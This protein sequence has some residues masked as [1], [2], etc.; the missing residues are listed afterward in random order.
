MT[1]VQR[2]FIAEVSSGVRQKNIFEAM[3]NGWAQSTD[4]YTKAL[5]S[6]NFAQER[7]QIYLEST[8]AK[9]AQLKAT[10]DTMFQN[11]MSSG[12]LNTVI[13]GVT[14]VAEAFSKVSQSVGLL[15]TLL[16]TAVV[17]LN[18]FGKFNFGESLLKSVQNYRLQ[19]S[20]LR[21]E[22]SALS[23]QN[24][25]MQV[26]TS[27]L[28]MMF[29]ALTGKTI[30]QTAA[31]VAL[32]LATTLLNAALTMGI[33]LAITGIVTAIG[34]W[35]QSSQRAKELQE[36]LKQSIDSSTQS[37]NQL[38]E[39]IATTNEKSVF[40]QNIKQINDTIKKYDDL[41]GKIK[42]VRDLKKTVYIQDYGEVE[43][44]SSYNPN[45]LT[46]S[47]KQQAAALR[48]N[49]SEFK[50][51]DDLLAEIKKRQSEYN[52][53]LLQSKDRTIDATKATID[54][55]LS[56]SE[57]I[58][59]YKKIYNELEIYNDII[60]KNTNGHK[61]SGK[62][63]ADLVEKYPQLIDAVKV[64]A[65]VLEFDTD[66]IN[67]MRQ[68]I[69]DNRNA[70]VQAQID[71]TNITI[72]STKKRIDAYMAEINS[73]QV[74]ANAYDNNPDINN[75]M[76]EHFQQVGATQ[77]VVGNLQDQLNTLEDQKANLEKLKSLISNPSFGVPKKDAGGTSTPSTSAE[78]DI[79]SAQIRSFNYASDQDK[80]ANESLKKHIEIAKQAKDYNDELKY[81]NLLL[82]GNKKQIDDIYSANKKI[83]EEKARVK[84]QYSFDTS[85]WFDSNG[86]STVAYEEAYQ[87][88]S[89][90]TQKEMK[91][92]FDALDKL[93]HAYQT[94]ANTI[95]SVI[96]S[97]SS[98]RQSLATLS[99]DL[100]KQ[101][102]EKEKEI[103]QIE[104][105]HQK[106]ILEKQ[107]KNDE[108]EL[109]SFK[110]THQTI[111]NG[112]QAQIDALQE[113]TNLETEEEERQ[114]RL[115]DIQTAQL[116]LTKAQQLLTNTL[117]DRNTR[118][119]VEGSGWIWQSNPK[120]VEKAQDDVEK[121]QKKFQSLQIEYQK[122]EQQTTLKHQRD[123]LQDQIKYEQDQIKNQEDSFNTLKDNLTTQMN[124]IQD[125]F[126][127]QWKNI[128]DM[129]TK[130]LDQFGGNVDSAVG[131]LSDKLKGLND[132]L[133]TLMGVTLPDS[134]QGIGGASANGKT[135]V[136]VKKGSPD[137]TILR[138]QYGDSI[139]IQYGSGNEFVG[140]DRIETNKM[141]QSIL[142]T[143]KNPVSTDQMWGY[144]D[145]GVNSKT[146]F[147]MLHG[148]SS[149][150][151]TIFNSTDSK[152]LWDFVHNLPNLSTNMMSNLIG[153]FKI[154]Q[155]TPNLAGVGSSGET[156][157]INGNMTIVTP[158][159]DDFF[160]QLKQRARLK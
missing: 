143:P 127:K 34:N 74:L 157:N 151:E 45:Q 112:Y 91:R 26:A 35:I 79:L 39:S 43:V 85:S 56:T 51:Y 32:T 97:Q 49:V 20:L 145:G 129:S 149:S 125:T 111:I 59:A 24:A 105:D 5:N 122:W 108:T 40:D 38:K 160:S 126:D 114:K 69:I 70:Q 99:Q 18:L 15:P 104:L 17:G 140:K 60:A 135:T 134:L 1:R 44:A 142:G 100:S 87:N 128:N 7:Q 158:N 71:A 82:S 124:T 57:I 78:A 90:S 84:S 123:Q 76:A 67:T 31:S 138:K 22:Q 103:A 2:S 156:I 6:S 25:G 41:A 19:L 29:Q 132:Q 13:S 21:M 89:A 83:E 48:I 23:T 159:P 3:M 136:I 115:L 88:A 68:A 92:E 147:H 96:D 9:I 150:A 146:G 154:P 131:V 155:F 47:L 64:H 65:G 66:V 55:V 42:E 14:G 33:S 130:L 81:T 36:Q 117:N 101:V 139:N 119:Y 46:D 52:D 120:D 95:Q 54:H 53:L 72:E 137:E 10:I 133:A 8:K 107:L 110:A 98:L 152:K 4:L 109:K 113:K 80:L 118:V 61:L 12:F 86:N 73:L 116:D 148:T 11:T 28:G 102:V 30:A 77:R 141:Y 153:N 62:E 63:I 27:G 50:S 121:T 106:D 144:A 37:F 58:T 93:N 94:N 75:A 16:T